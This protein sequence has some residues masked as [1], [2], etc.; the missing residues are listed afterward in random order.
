MSSNTH[1]QQHMK[2]GDVLLGV[3]LVVFLLGIGFV[4]SSAELAMWLFHGHFFH[5]TGAVVARAMFHFPKHLSNPAKAWPAPF[6]AELPD[7]AQYWCAIWLEVAV[8][9][10]AVPLLAVVG[11]IA[12]LRSVRTGP[13]D[14]RRS[15]LDRRTRAGVVAQGR[16]AKTS[17]LRPLFA[18]MPLHG[19]FLLGKVGWHHLATEPV[20]TAVRRRRRRRTTGP[21]A[22]AIVGP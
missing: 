19:R 4:W 17:E 11:G 20:W 12:L 5:V 13:R 22:V 10:L 9:L 1:Q 7:A 2:P 16:F 15:S 8:P 6:G 21:G 14:S 3:G 18:K